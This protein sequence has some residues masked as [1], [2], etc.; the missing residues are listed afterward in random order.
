MKILVGQTSSEQMQKA[1]KLMKERLE[2]KRQDCLRDASQSAAQQIA[3]EVWGD[4]KPPITCA[5]IRKSGAGLFIN[6]DLA[7][8]GQSTLTDGIAY[9]LL[10][11]KQIHILLRDRIPEEKYLA[12]QLSIS[13]FFYT[14]DAGYGQY[15]RERYPDIPYLKT[16]E[17]WKK[18]EEESSA[19]DHAEK[20]CSIVREVMQL[21]GT[22]L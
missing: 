16:I 13:M 18:D 3:V 5:D 8:F 6:F 4:T 1:I 22:P 20:L 14:A 11:C 7:G 12:K 2:Q 17:G 21:C 15:L 10:D 9:N 19:G